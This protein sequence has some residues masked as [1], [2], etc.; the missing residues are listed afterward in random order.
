MKKFILLLGFYTIAIL[1][2]A[3]QTY[4][5]GEGSK[6]NPYLISTKADMETLSNAV[7][8]GK[9]YDKEFFLLTENLTGITTIIGKNTKMF[10]GIFDGDG[11]TISVNINSS[12]YAGV[13]GYIGY[14]TIKN[15]GV[16]G[17]IASTS[18]AGGICGYADYET[19]FINCFNQA[20][21]FVSNTSEYNYAGGICGYARPVGNI[22]FSNCYNVGVVSADNVN[23]SAVAGGILGEASAT[24]TSVSVSISNCFNNGYI[25]SFASNF[26]A[27]VG[28][29]C[30]FFTG[31]GIISNCYN[32]GN[33][34][35]EALNINES[36]FS[37]GICGAGNCTISKC[38]N[39]GDITSNNEAGGIISG[40]GSPKPQI[41]DCFVANLAI[42][43]NPSNTGRIAS[44]ISYITVNNC[45]ALSS[46][47]VN[48]ETIYNIS[49]LNKHGKDTSFS[50][51]QS[52]SWIEPNLGWDFNTVWTMSS[53]SS[54]N[55]GLPIFKTQLQT[56]TITASA[57]SNGTISPSGNVSVNHGNSQPFTFTPNTGY[58]IN[59][60][61]I[62]GVN[63]TQAVSS[64][65][66]TF[67]NIT[68]NHTIS[69]TFKQLPVQTYTISASS[70]SNGSISP[71]GNI[72]V[73]HGNNQTFTFTPNTGYEINQVLID[74]VTNTQAVSSGS[75]TF[76]NVT[77]YH[78]IYVTF[79]QTTAQTHIITAF[80]GSGGAISPSGNVT[81]NHEN[82]QTF[83]FSPYTG[84]EINQVLVDGVNN[85]QAVSAGNYTFTNVTANHTI[86]VTFKQKQYTITV[87]AGA[88]GS[89]SPTSNQ[90]VAHGSSKAFS[91]TPN[92]G[93]EINQVLVDGV[94]NTTAVSAGNYTFT[95]VTANH[96]ISVTFKQKQYTITVSAGS[97]GSISPAS[98]QTVAHGSS[99]AFSFTPNTG[100]EINQV[101]VDGVNNT[102]AVSAGDYT[103][104]NVTANHTISVTFKQKQYTITVSAGSGGSI[105]PASNQTVAHGS[106]KAFSFSPNTGYE[107][108]QVLVDGVNNTTA[109]SSG[110]YTFS[111]VTANHTIS[112]TFKQKQYTIT[113][114][115]GS[116]GSISPASNQTVAHGSS[117]AFSF[118]P[119]TG[120]EIN[121]VLVDEVN[122]TQAVSAGNYTF[123]NVT[124]NHSISVNFRP[125]CR[126][127]LVIQIWDD[128]LSV[129]NEP[130]NN[131]GYVFVSYQ[132][133]KDGVNI[134]GETSGN[135]YF[136]D[137]TKDYTAQYS[138][139]LTTNNGQE[140][141]SC[142][143]N[144][145]TIEAGLRAFPNPA[146]GNVTIENETVHAGDII[147]VFDIHGQVVR[148]FTAGE[149]R[150]ILNLSSFRKGT[151]I[152]KVNNKQIK[153]LKN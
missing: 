106:S 136:P 24:Q 147:E 7:N 1:N 141:R 69:V 35:A 47:L 30:G 34:S 93:Y 118:I 132:W 11:H 37:G 61:L 95:N 79:K 94:N 25:T 8:N 100:Y 81:V 36:T 20:D 33:V 90:T 60:V 17:N 38:Y 92:T 149:N 131:G 72:I 89:I 96:T 111:N 135:I 40:G 3:A 134:P 70:G 57:E 32:I 4:S 28:G 41:S 46:I 43:G 26:S 18:Y 59:Q 98:N 14:A 71:S 138:V 112:V 140:M 143:V 39:I 13:F 150:T 84:Y 128:V 16:L 85:T 97:D 151:Y 139:L 144:L 115:A 75:Y 21:V 52:Q 137:E 76:S 142:P 120:Y 124:A 67:T 82:N 105:S 6:D 48:G 63:N 53:S 133:Q 102:T 2:I 114:S 109:V 126:P 66:Y 65:S 87:L 127:N 148:Q 12:A 62:D 145:R 23:R 78:T 123:T 58:E 113:V 74:G 54:V 117:K 45:Y 110:S 80:A 104:T 22:T 122:N 50:S 99:K 55:Q 125:A 31:N 56:Y 101:L 73:N 68:A 83:T 116:G 107:I 121:Q 91:F 49:T 146:S 153:V 64:G 103:F 27:V 77:N 152:I 44:D 130:A 51:F 86:S 129:V 108:N 15:L 10:R 88:D 119:N 29:I 9:S 42:L 19:D 5:G